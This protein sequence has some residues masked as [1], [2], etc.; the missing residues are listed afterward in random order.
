MVDDPIDHGIVGEE[1]DNL[2]RAAALR[3]DHGVNF[4][5]L[6]DHLGPALGRRTSGLLLHP[7]RERP[8]ACLPELSSMSVRVQA[9]VSDRD[10][11]LV[12]DMGTGF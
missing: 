11:A 5:D 3:T 2:H 4:E 7:E 6:A 9:V 10:L 8:K 1:S 12:R